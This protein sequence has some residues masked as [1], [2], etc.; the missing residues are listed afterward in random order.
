MGIAQ[1]LQQRLHARV[2]QPPTIQVQALNVRNRLFEVIA[3]L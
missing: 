1:A 3:I 2:A